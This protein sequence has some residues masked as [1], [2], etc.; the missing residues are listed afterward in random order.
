MQFITMAGLLACLTIA[1]LCTATAL[2]QCNRKTVEI[3]GASKLSFAVVGDWGRVGAEDS[4]FNPTTVNM[5]KNYGMCCSNLQQP[6]YPDNFDYSDVLDGPQQRY[7]ASLLNEV[8]GSAGC[9]FVLGMGD[10]FYPCG[11]DSLESG[12]NRFTS[13]WQNVYH[14]QAVPNIANLKWYQI[15]GNHDY[16]FNTSVD[17]QLGYADLDNRWVMP[18]TYYAQTFVA[19]DVSMDVE[20]LNQVPFIAPYAHPKPKKSYYTNYLASQITPSYI[21]SDAEQYLNATT[22]ICNVP[23]ANASFI[24]SISDG[25]TGQIPWLKSCLEASNATWDVVVGHFAMYGS[26]VNWFEESNK[27]L[28]PGNCGAFGSM[29]ALFEEYPIDAYFN[30]H[31]HTQTHADPSKKGQLSGTSPDYGNVT[32]TVNYDVRI[33]PT[34]YFTLGNGGSVQYGDGVTLASPKYFNNF[35]DVIYNSNVQYSASA[36]TD[37]ASDNAAVGEGFA[38]V[39]ADACTMEVKFYNIENYNPALDITPVHTAVMDKCGSTAAA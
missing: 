6:N 27:T 7:A 25:A 4:L 21:N 34:Q 38:I 32:Y 10:N 9:Q 11:A 22:G 35:T 36:I 28:Y 8:C 33:P 24:S 18:S 23:P 13:D 16:G 30:G 37:S 39:T 3:E 1:F 5:C 12:L 14:T 19:G 31:D 17:T 20:F 2:P 15:L 29:K 26:D